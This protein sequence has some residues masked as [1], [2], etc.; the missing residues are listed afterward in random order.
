MKLHP[1]G[2][3]DVNFLIHWFNSSKEK[4]GKGAH[5][6][7]EIIIPKKSIID[8]KK[9]LEKKKK[10]SDEES[11]DGYNKQEERL[12]RR[13]PKGVIIKDTL[14]VQMKKTLDSSKKLKGIELLSDVSE[15]EI[16]T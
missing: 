1:V 10:S 11:D 12:I 5:G 2:L 14:R 15:F 4:R 8:S 9:K 3:Q 13:K 6:T 7:K 16:N